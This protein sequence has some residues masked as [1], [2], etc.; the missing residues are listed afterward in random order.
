MRYCTYLP[1]P[2]RSD[3]RAK[4]KPWRRRALRSSPT[5]RDALRRRVEEAEAAAAEGRGLRE[6]A[7]AEAAVAKG[8]AAAK[9][10]A[11][12]LPAEI[13]RLYK[14]LTDGSVARSRASQAEESAR[15]LEAERD[16]VQAG[17]IA[18]RIVAQRRASG[19]G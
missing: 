11:Q 13:V 7:E 5:K 6:E 15:V 14:E 9:G 16:K 3:A 8:R 19:Q 4:S 10:G 17:H 2:L 1:S 12:A 18:I